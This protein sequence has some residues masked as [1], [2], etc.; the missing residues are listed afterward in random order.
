MAIP[1]TLPLEDFL[2]PLEID[3]GKIHGLARG[4]AVTY[5]RLAKESKDQF[6]STPISDSVLRPVGDEGER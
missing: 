5:L 4:L 3:I 2:R 1:E 6:L